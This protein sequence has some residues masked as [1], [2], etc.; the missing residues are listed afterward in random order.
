MT[1]P[2]QEKILDLPA[3]RHQKVVNKE[4]IQLTKLQREIKVLLKQLPLRQV[5]FLLWI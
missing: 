3:L 5:N 4:Q 2:L 1:W